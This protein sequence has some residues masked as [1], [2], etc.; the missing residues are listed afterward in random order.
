MNKGSINLCSDFHIPIV[1]RILYNIK[2]IR[3]WM[4]I[5][6]LGFLHCILKYISSVLMNYKNHEHVHIVVQIYCYNK[7]GIVL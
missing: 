6:F 7:C 1:V 5:L 4:V 3:K 2:K